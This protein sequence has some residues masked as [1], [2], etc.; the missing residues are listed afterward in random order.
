MFGA[1]IQKTWGLHLIDPDLNMGDLVEI[2]GEE[3]KAYLA[4]GGS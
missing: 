1:Q 3:S 2:V 4:Q